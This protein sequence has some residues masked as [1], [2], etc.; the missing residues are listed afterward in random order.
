MP[1]ADAGFVIMEQVEY[2]PMSGTNTI[3][4]ATVAARDRHGAGAA[5]RSPSSTLETPAGLIR[6][7]AAVRDGKCRRASPSATCPP[8]P[9]IWIGPIEVPELGTLTVDVGVRRHVLRDRGGRGARLRADARRGPRHRPRGRDDQGSGARAAARCPSREPGDSRRH[10]RR[11]CTGRRTAPT[12]DPPQRRR[13]P[14]APSTGSALPPGRA[15]S[16]ARR[17]A[18][19]PARHGRAAR[20]GAARDSVRTSS[21][22][23]SLGTVFTGRLIEETRVGTDPRRGAH[24]HRQRLDHRD[25]A[26]RDRSHRPVPRGVHGRRSVGLGRRGAPPVRRVSR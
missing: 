20:Q 5:S 21:T 14:P 12:L 22:R 10:D 15:C 11:S 19:A 2:P 23:A 7:Q 4:V 26:V 8:S 17:A 24:P 1:E 3:C 25:R 9:P 18:P 13:S 16:T 6:V